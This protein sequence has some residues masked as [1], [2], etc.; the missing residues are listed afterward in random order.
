M[1]L[2]VNKNYLTTR[3][4]ILSLTTN[5][6]VHSMDQLSLNKLVN[7][8]IPLVPGTYKLIIK[9]PMSNSGNT[10]KILNDSHEKLNVR[11]G[12]T[13]YSEYLFTI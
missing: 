8:N 1:I 11:M 10:V 5:K 12:N 13:K 6:F 4:N 3:W 2:N 7:R 9:N